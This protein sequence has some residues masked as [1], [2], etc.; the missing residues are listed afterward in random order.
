MPKISKPENLFE[1]FDPSQYEEE[2]RRRWGNTE[3]WKESQRRGRSYTAAD[4]DAI[5]KEGG[6]IIGRLVSVMDRKPGD[7]AAQEAIA[8]HHRQIN[9]RFYT[10]TPEI[11]RGLANAYADDPGFRSFYEGIKPGL[12]GFMRDCML[13]YA[14]TLNA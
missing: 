1:G 13:I 2:A 12:A 4:W 5:K 10:C 7:R 11:Y 8:A 9:Q 14:D 3:A 6:E